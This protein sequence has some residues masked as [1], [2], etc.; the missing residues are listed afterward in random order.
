MDIETLTFKEF[1]DLQIPI[2]ITSYT[3]SKL[4]RL[5]KIDYVNLK[6][7]IQNKN[8]NDVELLVNNLWKD[9]LNYLVLN[10]DSFET[11]F[12]H[13]LGDFDGYFLIKGLLSQENVNIKNV[14]TII[15]DKNKW[16]LIRYSF[17]KD[18]KPFTISWRDSLRIFPVSLDKLTKNFNVEG[19]TSKYNILFNNIDVFFDS[20]LYSSFKDY[21]MQDSKSLHNALLTAQKI[22]LSKYQ[23]DI[24]QVLSTSSLS[25]KIF[26]KNFLNTDIPILV[27]S[28]DAFIRKSYFG[29]ATDIFKSRGYNLR[30]YDINSLYP[31]AMLKP[32]PLELIKKHDKISLNELNDFFGFILCNIETPNNIK[33]PILPYRALGKTFYPLGKWKG[34]Y[35]SEEIKEAIKLGYKIE[36]LTGYEFSKYNLFDDYINHF[37]EIKKN[38]QGSQRFI[39]KMHLNQLYG[40]FGRKQDVIESVNIY[41]SELL[42]YVKTRVIKSITE[43]PNGNYTL[44]L[45]NNLLSDIV[46]ELE[47]N[48]SL[49]IKGGKAIVKSNVAIASAVTSYARIH[50]IPFK[51]NYDVYY[52]DTDSIFTSDKL[53]DSLVG[54]DLGLMKDELDGLLIKEAIFLG[55]KQYGYYY[56]DKNNKKIEKS[57][58]SGVDR[59]SLK[60]SEIDELSTGSVITK[61]APF[62][63][64]KSLKNLTIRI[65]SVDIVLKQNNNKIKIN[66]TKTTPCLPCKQV[67]VLFK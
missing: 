58:L 61:S 16:I 52:S 18:G 47:E 25:L 9:Y 29:G 27:E 2:I 46:K 14:N 63:F 56:Y 28:V 37:Y 5:F 17:V 49:N 30:Y 21:A 62:R 51:L 66:K 65:K 3:N 67:G 31:N 44:L 64:F 24:C 8:L 36:P 11:I 23:V 54:K 55:L 22:Y 10:K 45:Y 57:V 35:F 60:F 40:I 12:V 4:N 1:D 48:V 7:A 19:K 43:L 50:M 32:M 26:R 13:N 34:V 39:A 38:S 42:D 59:D 15:D 53:P 20:N 41:G 6:Q 33:I